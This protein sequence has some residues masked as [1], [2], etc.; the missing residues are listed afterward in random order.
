MYFIR[1]IFLNIH[2]QYINNNIYIIIYISYLGATRRKTQH[3]VKASTW[4]GR[5]RFECRRDHHG[6]CKSQSNL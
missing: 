2:I 6:L 3:S 1:K 4:R 5:A